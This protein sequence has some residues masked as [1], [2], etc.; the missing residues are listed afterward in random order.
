M[1]IEQITK[2]IELAKEAANGKDNFKEGAVGSNGYGFVFRAADVNPS[3][4]NPYIFSVS[5]QK[6]CGAG[7][8]RDFLERVEGNSLSQKFETIRNISHGK[9]SQ[10]DLFRYERNFDLRLAGSVKTLVPDLW[11]G[12]Y[13]RVFDVWMFAVT[14]E[15]HMFP[16]TLYWRQSGLSFGAWASY[17]MSYFLKERFFPEDFVNLINFTPF[18]SS[19]EELNL[20]L[21]ALEFALKKVPVSDFWGVNLAD[22]GYVYIGIK[23][24]V[25]FERPLYPTKYSND[26]EAGKELESLLGKKIK[27]ADGESFTIY[28]LPDDRWLYCI[29]FEHSILSKG[30]NK[31]FNYAGFILDI[32]NKIMNE[33]KKKKQRRSLNLCLGKNLKPKMVIRLLFTDYQ[34]TNGHTVLSLS[35]RCG[36]S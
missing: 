21:D 18:E 6:L 17:G 34:T 20:F 1:G 14:P 35:L 25:P 13:E 28:R 33:K 5:S 2:I 12:G 24:G 32:Y 15:G 10:V 31:M 19:D 27:T 8:Q 11:F 16:A 22:Y 3:P 7:A 23:N 36:K 30:R 26:A 4:S 29:E 9:I